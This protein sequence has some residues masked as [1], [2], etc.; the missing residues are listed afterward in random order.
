MPLRLS[1]LTST[2]LTCDIFCRVVDNY[3]DIGVT[4]RLARQ[5][6]L[7]HGLC[8][9]LIVDDLASFVKLVPAI[10]ATS[11]EQVIDGVAVVE[12]LEPIELTTPAVLIIEAFGC[13]LPATYVSSMARQPIA[14]VWIN[15]E[16]LSAE[17]WV[18]SHHLL[19]SPHTLHPLTK[20]FFFPGFTEKTG[21]LIRENDLPV[22]R[23]AA[24]QPDADATLSVFIFA[25]ENCPVE[26]LVLAMGKMGPALRCH[27]SEGKV[28][29]KLTHWC[30]YQAKNA[31]EAAPVLEFDVVP[32]VPQVAFDNLLQKHDV[33]FVRG[34]DS[35]VRALWAAKPFVWHIY[36]QSEDAHW[37]KL[38]AFLDLYCRDLPGAAS[39]AL[40]ELW[41]A[42]NA[43]DGAAI[44]AAWAGF[45]AQL[46]EL[47][48]YA[49]AWSNR[50]SKLPDLARNLLSFYQKTSKI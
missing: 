48:R 10:D 4:W 6:N 12:W 43:N 45:Y 22:S 1:G 31:S 23:D 24:I 33:L 50:Q 36:P 17:A 7:E 8:V 41:R 11:R 42:W 18:E 32:F 47:R 28:A 3:G 20:Y 40:R 2:T 38:N 39:E 25:Y 44:E 30:A 26:A 27:V 37:V 35:L 21:G 5:L 29:D 9:R 13:D 14:P 49:K 15:L 16:Y 34:E 19:P 46:A